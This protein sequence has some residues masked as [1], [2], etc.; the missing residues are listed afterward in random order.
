MKKNTDIV[1]SNALIE[2]IYNPGSIY[3]MRLLMAVLLQMKS[4]E[5][6]DCNQRYYVTA[7][8]L[9]SL[10]GAKNNYPELRKA[11]DSL[12]NTQ[13]KITR[14][15]DGTSRKNLL[16][17]NL[18]SSCEYVDSEGQ[19]GIRFTQEIAPYL[20]ELRT[21]FTTYQAEHVMPMRS[22]YGVRMY[23][24]SLQWMGTEREFTI[25]EFKALFELEN[26][27]PRL[28]KL[29]E[30]VIEPALKDINTHS[31]IQVKFSQRKR[32]RVVTHFIFSI[33]RPPKYQP[34][35]PLD[36]ERWVTRYKLAKD[37]NFPDWKTAREKLGNAYAAYRKDP[38]A[39]VEKNCT[40]GDY[41]QLLEQCGQERLLA[42]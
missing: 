2:A 36:F 6:L 9:A 39:W 3:Q 24:L 14:N 31:N 8:E 12:M 33:N 40:D 19:V 16:K 32:G 26:H 30:R 15:P 18:V 11:A 1:K 13:V 41:R 27:Y 42:D 35:E 4:K 38:L 29:K 20:S 23:E 28:G 22:G 7:T 37:K 21:R 5:K 10:T 34:I 17:A 25:K